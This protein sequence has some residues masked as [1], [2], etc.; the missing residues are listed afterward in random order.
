[1]LHLISIMEALEDAGKEVQQLPGKEASRGVLAALHEG[2]LQNPVQEH[3]AE[4]GGVPQGAL[5][6][7]VG[8]EH[9][10]GLFD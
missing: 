8:G 6:L 5:V 4:G 2:L 3:R 7:Q 10:E 9:V 1:M